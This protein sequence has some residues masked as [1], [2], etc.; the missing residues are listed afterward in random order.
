MK[1]FHSWAKEPTELC[2]TRTTRFLLLT[3]GRKGAKSIGA[4]QPQNPSMSAMSV[5]SSMQRPQTYLGT[6]KPTDRWTVNKQSNVHTVRKDMYL[7]QLY[8]CTF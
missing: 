1:R 6:N 3:G 2:P 7:C 8:L 5:E 4:T